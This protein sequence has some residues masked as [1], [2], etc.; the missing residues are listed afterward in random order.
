MKTKK[1]SVLVA[2][3]LAVTVFLSMGNVSAYAKDGLIKNY[4]GENIILPSITDEYTKISI[5]TADDLKNLAALC[6]LDTAS[7]KLYVELAGDI[8]LKGE[9]FVPIPYF[10]GI[11]NGNNYVISGLSTTNTSEPVG[12]FATVGKGALIENLTVKGSLMPNESC[13]YLG[14]IAGENRGI[15]YGC[16]F[17]GVVAG[18]SYVGGIAGINTKTGI[19]VN[20]YSNGAVRGAS[21]T[22]GIAGVNNGTI[23]NCENLALINTENAD[24]GLNVSDIDIEFSLDLTKIYKNRGTGTSSQKDMGGIAGYSSGIISGCTNRQE[25]GYLHTGYNVGGIAGR[26]SGYIHNCFNRSHIT[27]RKDI[28]GIVGQLE[29]FVLTTITESSLSI[30]NTQLE[31][32]QAL[33]EKTQKDANSA[34]K[35]VNSRVD[36]I[37][38]YVG[39]A[40]DSAA[41]ISSKTKEKYDSGQIDTSVDGLK[42]NPEDFLN[43]KKDQYKE[44]I[45]NYSEADTQKSQEELYAAVSGLNSQ[46]KLLNKEA[47]GYS[48][49]LDS[50]LQAVNNKYSEIQ[51]TIY[52]IGD[53]S[54]EVKDT[55]VV[56]VDLITLGAVRGCEN[57]GEIEGD[58]NVAGIAGAMGQE[59]TVDPEDE[60]SLSLDLKTHK[61]YE[62]KAVIDDCVNNGVISTK[63]NYCAGI[64]GRAEVGYIR[65]CENYGEIKAGGSYAGGIAAES[66]IV[67]R[68]CYSKCNLSGDKYVGGIIGIGVS[69]SA[70]GDSSVVSDCRS[71]VN[72]TDATKFYGA[73]SS[74]T[75]GNFDNNIFVSDTLLGLGSMSIAGAAGPVEY[76]TLI[77]G[78]V[79]EAF[80]LLTVSFIAGDTVLKTVEFE[81]GQSLEGSVYPALPEKKGSFARWDITELNNLKSDTK[82][83]AVYTTYISALSSDDVRSSKRSV[84]YVEGDFSD[85]QVLLTNVVTTG[86]YEVEKENTTEIYNLFFDRK[87]EEQWMVVIPNDGRES[88]V[89]RYLPTGISESAPEIYVYE[90]DGWQKADSE[91]YGSYYGFEVKG[92]KVKVAVVTSTPVYGTFAITAGIAVILLVIIIVIIRSVHSLKKRREREDQLREERIKEIIEKNSANGAE[93]QELLDLIGGKTLKDKSDKKPV[94]KGRIARRVIGLVAVAAILTP[95]ILYV[96]NPSILESRVADFFIRTMTGDESAEYNVT[97][98]LNAVKF[99]EKIDSYVWRKSTE[100]GIITGIETN[101]VKFFLMGDRLY[102][103]N[104]KA[105][106]TS[107]LLPDYNAALE[108][109]GKS[110][111]C[112]EVSVKKVDGGTEHTVAVNDD[113]A[114]SLM[115]S[116]IGEYAQDIDNIRNV[117]ATVVSDNW[118]AKEIRISCNADLKSRSNVNVVCTMEIVGDE[119][120]QTHDIPKEVMTAIEEGGDCL[121]ITKDMLEVLYAFGRFATK[122]PQAAELRLSATGNVLG[123]TDTLS[124]NRSKVKGEWIGSVEKNGISLYY[125]DKG[126]CTAR[127]VSLTKEQEE[128]VSVAALFDYVYDSCRNGGYSYSESGDE[129]VYKINLNGDE[130][131]SMAGLLAPD[132]ED[133]DI[134]LKKGT[135]TVYVA[136]GEIEE[137]NIRISGSVKLILLNRSIGLNLRITPMNVTGNVEIPA[138]VINTLLAK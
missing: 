94:K 11:F 108:T 51:D 12:L 105:F 104:G 24:G 56:D 21:M 69:E 44:N 87:L 35:Q 127:G 62:Y 84:F 54:F 74:T 2:I 23:L 96:L 103:E 82:V 126:A 106:N 136:Q 121:T 83:S 116:V 27:G 135:V 130:M 36:K 26:S 70:D 22:G 81:Y 134:T 33:V 125:T 72:I 76:E 110:T 101:G 91:E 66:Q 59:S 102:L 37:S 89:L 120:R 49:L 113:M 86:L 71:I 112:Y 32:M 109:I 114:I 18:S 115:Q 14:G 67:I 9:E 20:C 48:D 119:D 29:P 43:Q 45:N 55:S 63:R 107:E 47:A 61:E 58:L 52:N 34:G 38:N 128:T 97:L 40:N 99:N 13:S 68:N 132:L 133:Y 124:W 30:L 123:I 65:D 31:E 75:D 28:G 42:E 64:T 6:G 25:V 17:S 90:D 98:E 3:L 85:D 111:E 77:S 138:E 1:L 88:H 78:D 92:T 57:T 15:I 53:T 100:K 5:K 39:K 60:I 73:V 118:K 117:K 95:I 7:E 80:K 19:I 122:D 131:Q 50:D 8:S 10:G 79:P 46:I 137:I 4:D 16:S 129:A 41:D 93:N